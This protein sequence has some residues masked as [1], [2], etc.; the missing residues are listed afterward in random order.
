M[1]KDKITNKEDTEALDSL[2]ILYAK[3]KMSGMDKFKNFLYYNKFA[4]I[5]GALAVVILAVLI[6]QFATKAS[7][8][9]SIMYTGRYYINPEAQTN[10]DLALKTVLTDDYNGDGKVTLQF[11]NRTVK[12]A[13]KQQQEQ[14]ESD[15]QL[16]NSFSAEDLSVFNTELMAG[17]S[18]I[19]FIDENLYKNITDK[20]RFVELKTLLGDTPE[21]S[22]D[23]YAVYLKDTTF[24]SLCEELE[25]LG[26]DTV[27]C[28]KRRVVTCDKEKY[29]NNTD[30]FKK[31]FD[32]VG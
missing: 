15:E 7:P 26:E 19:C 20:S 27:V 21:K 4:L 2:D 25:A 23:E 17:E 16:Y 9:V 10:I 12:T 11:I 31:L 14:D 13:D 18:V 32:Y 3:P 22:V 30:A 8:D 29:E 5:A 1:E 6:T 28:I 24:A